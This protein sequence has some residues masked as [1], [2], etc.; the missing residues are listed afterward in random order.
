MASSGQTF[1]GLP[2]RRSSIA[3]SVRAFD[4]R[5]TD[6]RRDRIRQGAGDAGDDGRGADG[7][8]GVFR[9]AVRGRGQGG[10][11]LPPCGGGS[12]ARSDSDVA[13][14]GGGYDRGWSG[15]L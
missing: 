12:V 15:F 6:K 10:D 9:A 11:H 2:R 13:E 7:G 1:S 3:Y 5:L 8:G 14:L 4:G